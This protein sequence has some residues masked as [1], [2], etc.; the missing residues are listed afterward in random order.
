MSAPATIDALAAAH[1]AKLDRVPALTDEPCTLALAARM[2][3]KVRW[4]RDVA[5]E[6]ALGMLGP[7]GMAPA[8]D[9]VARDAARFG[10]STSE[11]KAA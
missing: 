5:R 10:F 1:L 11:R 7:N 4:Y 6:I 3:R 8:I 2:A 9:L